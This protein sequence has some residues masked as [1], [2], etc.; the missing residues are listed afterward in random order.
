MKKVT[1]YSLAEEL[2]MTPT[3]VSRAFNPNA[4]IAEGKRALVLSTAKKY[5]FVPNKFAS[6]LSMKAIKIGIIL[7]YKAEH[8]K[9]QMISGIEDAYNNLKDYK[10]EYTLK[11]ISAKEKTPAECESDLFSF[12]DFDGVILSGFSNN[13]FKPMLDRFAAKNTNIVFLQSVCEDTNYLF[14]SKHDEI[15]ASGLA[16]EIISDRLSHSDRK[17]ILLFTGDQN[18]SVHKQAK[19][20]FLSACKEHSLNVIDCIDMRDR[21][22]D[23]SVLSETAL[24]KHQGEFDGIYITSGNCVSLCEAIKVQNIKTS[25][26][27]FDVFSKLYPYIEDKTVCATIF[28]NVRVQSKTAFSKLCDFIINKKKIEKTVY[29]D[30]LP[31]FKSTL[32]LYK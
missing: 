5:N 2:D 1:I 17:N 12:A 29:T 8:L 18:S 32:K 7:Y 27:T 21:E 22:E 24:K 30:V 11:I 25:L 19:K 10:I 4:K 26:V 23:L 31:V 9:N 28:Q 16:A 13:A 3:M 6:R 15:L 20:A 14:A